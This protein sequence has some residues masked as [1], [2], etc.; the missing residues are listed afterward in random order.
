M[1]AEA[2]PVTAES[3]RFFCT[4]GR[5]MERFVVDEVT[6]K[7][8]AAEVEILPG[9]VFFTGKPDLNGIKNV[10][11]A[12]RMFLLLMKGPPVYLAKHKG[13]ISCVYTKIYHWGTPFVARITANMA[14]SSETSF[15]RSNFTRTKES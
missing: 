11:S 12:E 7:V 6:R 5:G 9:K 13:N 14:V 4:A 8:S 15:K 3:V 2:P 1:T 10:K